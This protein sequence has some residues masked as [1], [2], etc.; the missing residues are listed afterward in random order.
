MSRA[1][2]LCDAYAARRLGVGSVGLCA[3]CADVRC[4]EQGRK[5]GDTR[6]HWRSVLGQLSSGKWIRLKLHVAARL[7]VY[8]FCTRMSHLSVSHRRILS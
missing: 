3:E 7:R 2:T 5:E 6:D 1:A 4:E 8:G